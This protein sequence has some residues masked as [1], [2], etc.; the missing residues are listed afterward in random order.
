[1]LHQPLSRVVAG[2]LLAGSTVAGFSQI[3]PMHRNLLQLGFD[4]P[5]ENHGPQAAYLYYYYNNPEFIGTNVTL[6]MAIAPVYFDGELG[7]KELISP[8]TDVGVGLYGGMYGDNYY[9]VRQ[10]HLFGGE[11]FE[12]H[13][14]G[15]AL[16]IYQLVNPGMKIPLSVIARGGARYANYH[17]G[18]ATLN[19]FEL[20]DDRITSYFRGG[21]RLAGKE[22]VLYPDLGMELSV[23]YEHQF[24]SKHDEYGLADDRATRQES[25]LYWLYAGINYTWTNIGH[26]ISFATTIGGSSGTDRFSAWRLGG[27]LPLVSEYPLVLPGYYYQEITAK[28]FAHFYAS[29]LIPLDRRHRFQFQLEAASACLSYLPGF[30]QDRRWQTGAGAGLTFTPDNDA[31]RIVLRY[32]YGFNALRDGKEGASSV[33]LLFQYDFEQRF[34]K[35]RE[36]KS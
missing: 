28:E 2:C 29:Y 4:L 19:S 34:K 14:G 27:V 7:F 18:D 13:G 16:S 31:F 32:G 12:G 3:D 21:L 35:K 5:L 10:G 15:L 6:R 17:E 36:A 24:R 1:M 26:K 33:G 22:P 8:T 30:E 20:P 23:W 25:E 11:S 9:E